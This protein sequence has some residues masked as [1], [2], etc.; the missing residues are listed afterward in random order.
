MAVV[1][2][3]PSGGAPEEGL[4]FSRRSFK[5]LPVCRMSLPQKVDASSGLVS[6]LTA[7]GIHLDKG[8]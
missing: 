7:T 1:K 4:P 8:P 5:M 3:P 6:S 2:D